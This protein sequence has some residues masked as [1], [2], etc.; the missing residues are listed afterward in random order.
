M[1]QVLYKH[2]TTDIYNKMTISETF[3]GGG[4]GGGR[5]GGGGVD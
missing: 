1:F 4:G 2:I 3:G 5:G